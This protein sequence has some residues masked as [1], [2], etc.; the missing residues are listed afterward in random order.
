MKVFAAFQSVAFLRALATPTTPTSVT[1]SN[2]DTQLY[3][4]SPATRS[5]VA[6]PCD[7]NKNAT[8]LQ[9]ASSSDSYSTTP[10]L[11]L[12]SS[13]LPPLPDNSRR[14]YL[15]R[16]GETD[17]NLQGKIQG[18]GFDIPLN[19]NGRNQAL[20]VA[21]ALHGIPIGVVASSHLARAAE[22]ADILHQRHSTAQRR[23][24]AGFAEMSFGA[25]EGL[26][27]R[28]VDVDP[29]VKERFLSI[30]RQVKRNIDLEFPGGGESTAQV[31]QRATKALQQLLE[32]FPARQQQHI[33]IVS[34]G[35]TN[36]VLIAATA[37]DD[38]MRFTDVKQ[39]SK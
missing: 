14:V 9:L 30:S 28:D 29:V 32:E 1:T 36:K 33:A 5:M 12:L 3:Q 17:W 10:K 23:R 4:I 7:N 34:H 6:A 27:Y 39:S 2:T 35:R 25:F 15:L 24:D 11:I 22:T 31:Q 16:H 21:E 38:V 20:A 8:S 26:A 18:G 19:E 13:I 37:M